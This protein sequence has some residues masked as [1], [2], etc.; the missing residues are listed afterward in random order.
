[1]AN[2]GYSSKVLSRS[3]E[4]NQNTQPQT[5][6]CHEQLPSVKPVTIRGFKQNRRADVHQDADE[7][8]MSSH[9]QHGTFRC[10]ATVNQELVKCH[11]G[12]G[13]EAEKGQKPPSL[14]PRQFQAG[15]KA[16]QNEGHRQF[17]Q[18]ETDEQRHVP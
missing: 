5:H 1:M 8:T 15:Q 3:N 6:H 13:H 12:E 10:L 4:R 11:A 16:H 7:Q 9:R 2:F 14:E 17:V 18:S